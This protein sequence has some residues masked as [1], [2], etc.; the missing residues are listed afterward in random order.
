MTCIAPDDVE[1]A[2][3]LSAAELV[4][5]SRT[6]LPAKDSA[7]S[8]ST[9]GSFEEQVV[10]ALFPGDELLE[11]RD[12][13][14]TVAEG[15]IGVADSPSKAASSPGAAS[16]RPAVQGRGSSFAAGAAVASSAGVKAGNSANDDNV[17]PTVCA[18]DSM[19]ETTLH[20]TPVPGTSVVRHSSIDL[21]SRQLTRVAPGSTTDT[22]A[23]GQS[24][25]DVLLGNMR[26]TYAKPGKAS[27][28]AASTARL[29]VASATMR[30][31]SAIGGAPRRSV[32]TGSPLIGQQSLTTLPSS[33]P[34]TLVSAGTHLT[35]G[36][37]LRPP[38]K[39]HEPAK[40]DR[41]DGRVMLRGVRSTSDL[42]HYAGDVALHSRKGIEV[43]NAFKTMRSSQHAAVR[44]SAWNALHSLRASEMPIEEWYT[45]SKG[46][47]RYKMR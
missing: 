28:Q 10:A 38:H 24:D 37:S 33:P 2:R 40:Y 27:P 16:G 19:A 1:A 14:Y 20:T 41:G 17:A 22:W 23:P 26:W 18:V 13:R 25:S 34:L 45:N 32:K 46:G 47:A 7:R 43:R 3:V 21:D 39:R 11:L 31:A 9:E 12:P 4:Q 15:S 44:D 35:M 36:K 42:E 5:F 29:P 6:D 30:G 8:V